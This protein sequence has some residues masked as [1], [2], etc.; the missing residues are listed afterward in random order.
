VDLDNFKMVNDRHGHGEGDRAIAIAARI[1][2]EGAR[3][4]DLVA[5]VGGDEFAMILLGAGPDEARVSLERMRSAM[6]AA[7]RAND[8]PITV[9]VGALSYLDAPPTLEH[10]LSQAD[11]LMYRAKEAGK[12]C[13]LV[14]VASEEVP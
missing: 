12:D 7:M 4:S 5:R 10:A 8:W 2:G 11:S 9:S 6:A 14:D 1:L 13:I 3:A